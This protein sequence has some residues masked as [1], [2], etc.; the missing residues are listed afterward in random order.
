MPIVHECAADECHTLTMGVL[1]L[2]HELELA[3]E[4]RLE[5]ADEPLAAEL[6]AAPV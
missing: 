4:A 3:A 5:D 6:D 1:C 2:E